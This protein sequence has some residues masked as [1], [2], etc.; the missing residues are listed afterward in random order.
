MFSNA[1]YRQVLILASSQSLFQTVSVMVMTIG[2]L[3][4]ANIANSPTLATLPIASMFLGTALMMF[5]AS[6]LMA[7]IGRRKGFLCGALL[8]V[9]GGII[10]AIGIYYHSLFTLAFGTACVGAYQSFAQ[11]YR[12]AASEV[13][14][15]NFRSKAI[16]FVMAG[17]IVAAL[18]GPTLARLGGAL[19]SGFEYIGSFLIIT[20]V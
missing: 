11:F 2:G 14:D 16:S 5:P 1:M 20:I 19:F 13:A 10:A 9:L 6:M 7:H 3:A 18:I 4:G 15:D 17:G 12:F 8:G